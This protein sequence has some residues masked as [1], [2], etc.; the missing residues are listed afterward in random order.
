MSARRDVC[1]LSVDLHMHLCLGRL[2]T[3]A[4][5][6]ATRP[7]ARRGGC[8]VHAHLRIHE[9]RL[10]KESRVCTRRTADFPLRC[11]HNVS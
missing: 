7:G 4:P 1:T 9:P 5:A 10:N 2:G 6:N 3:A 11:L 8:N